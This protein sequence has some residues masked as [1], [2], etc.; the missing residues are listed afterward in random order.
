MHAPLHD[1]QLSYGPLQSRIM[2]FDSL[3]S[4]ILSRAASKSSTVTDLVFFF[5]AIIAASLIKLARS[6]PENPGVP[7]AILL[8]STVLD[9]LYILRMEPENLF[10][11]G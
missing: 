3:P 1:T 6:A 11:A 4:K 8:K 2:V 5:E 7:R 9:H 10:S